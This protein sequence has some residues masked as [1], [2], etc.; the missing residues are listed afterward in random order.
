MW[1]ESFFQQDAGQ[2]K[3]HPCRQTCQ[4]ELKGIGPVGLLG[5]RRRID[6]A[7]LCSLRTLGKIGC[8]AGLQSLRQKG[9]IVS[10]RLLMISGNVRQLLLTDRRE[11]ESS[12]ILLDLVLQPFDLLFAI[13]NFQLVRLQLALKLSDSGAHWVI[14]MAPGLGRSRLRV[15]RCCYGMLL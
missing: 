6:N 9:F 3:D 10:A 13:G 5:E 2:A 8:H 4:A 14:S 1:V 11:V 15:C 12:L 7:E